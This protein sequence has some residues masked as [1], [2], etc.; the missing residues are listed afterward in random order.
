MLF[1]G[2]ILRVLCLY[3]IKLNKIVYFSSTLRDLF[4]DYKGEKGSGGL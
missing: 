3:A 2:I 1:H 4:Q